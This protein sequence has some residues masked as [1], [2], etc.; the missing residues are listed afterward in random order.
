MRTKITAFAK[1]RFAN[2]YR[3]I[4]QQQKEQKTRQAAEAAADRTTSDIRRDSFL[5]LTAS[6]KSPKKGGRL[7]GRLARQ[8]SKKT[9]GLVAELYEAA[10]QDVS[11]ELLKKD[12]GH[13][14]LHFTKRQ[15]IETGQ[16]TRVRK[17]SLEPLADGVAEPASPYLERAINT[18]QPI[19]RSSSSKIIP[20]ESLP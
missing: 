12:G 18:S 6:P 13:S 17:S 10:R 8:Y 3:N 19:Q 14:P 1:L 9:A 5:G 7:K 11:G 15:S 4:K 20:E 2:N 16:N